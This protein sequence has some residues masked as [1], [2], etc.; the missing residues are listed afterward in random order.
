MLSKTA[1][2]TVPPSHACSNVNRAAQVA[3]DTSLSGAHSCM[4]A[5]LARVELPEA[6]S[7]ASERFEHLRLGEPHRKSLPF[8][9]Y[10]PL[11]IAWS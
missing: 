6:L 10:Q 8:F 11:P 4:S 3:L 9:G 2:R 5:N 1:R 7:E